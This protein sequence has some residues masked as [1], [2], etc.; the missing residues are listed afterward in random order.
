MLS[1]VTLHCQV[2]KIVM[3]AVFVVVFVAVV[4]FLLSKL[5]IIVISVRIVKKCN[6]FLN[7]QKLSKIVEN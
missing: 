1:S 7:C 6:F 5:S 2:T 3:N 4:V